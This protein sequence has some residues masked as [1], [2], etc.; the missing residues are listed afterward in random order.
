MSSPFT[1]AFMGDMGGE[2]DEFGLSFV[3]DPWSDICPKCGACSLYCQY[4]CYETNPITHC[5]MCWFH[6]HQ[7]RLIL[8]SSKVSNQALTK[9]RT[10]ERPNM[11]AIYERW[12]D[13]S[14]IYQAWKWLN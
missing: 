3:Q 1:D 2:N 10:F 8:Q 7:G 4:C 5:R 9:S 14:H 11:D 13:L 12:R 6:W